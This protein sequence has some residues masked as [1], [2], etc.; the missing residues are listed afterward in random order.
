MIYGYNRTSFLFSFLLIVIFSCN[1]SEPTIN[2]NIQISTSA[3]TSIGTT[4][5]ISGGIISA[6]NGMG[7]SSRGVCWSLNIDPTIA[8]FKTIDGT[9][10]GTFTSNISG[11]LPNTT[12]YVK[13]YASNS[14]GV[15][16]GNQVTLTTSQSQAGSFTDYRD[17]QIYTFKQIGSQIWMTQNLNY[18]TSG[19]WC[20]DNMA[21]NCVMYGRLYEWNTAAK[22]AP[23]GWHLP[24][25]QEWITLKT[26]LGGLESG[27][28]MKATTLWL[29]P[30]TAATNVSGFTGLP[31]GFRKSASV[32]FLSLTYYGS[33]WSSTQASLNEAWATK[34]S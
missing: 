7:V 2:D 5:A 27:G 21:S 24:S 30:N 23:K 9:G 25:D 32:G 4:N 33:W 12:Y 8:N 14:A 6:N 20:Y 15:A 34:L 1:K 16:Y 10:A 29:N 17:G 31:G 11:L 26:Y 13:A 22:V 28:K 3:I 18:D 19:S